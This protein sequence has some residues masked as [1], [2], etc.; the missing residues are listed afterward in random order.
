MSCATYG[1]GAASR[2]RRSACTRVDAV[3]L[4]GAVSPTMPRME[5]SASAS[6]P[7]VAGMALPIGRIGNV[8]PWPQVGIDEVGRPPV[9]EGRHAAG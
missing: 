5:I 9:S 1:V 2:V 4:D 8:L 6:H 7:Q 3:H